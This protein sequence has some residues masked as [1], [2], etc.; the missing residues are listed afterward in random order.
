M[1]EGTYTHSTDDYPREGCKATIHVRPHGYALEITGPNNLPME[2]YATVSSPAAISR[3]L[4]E[5]CEGKKPA[6]K[7]EG[8]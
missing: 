1:P 5:W 3:M 2:A 4:R 6:L 7:G 8:D